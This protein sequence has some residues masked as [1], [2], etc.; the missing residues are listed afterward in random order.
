M[1][2]TL[3]IR[4]ELRESYNHTYAQ[5]HAFLGQTQILPQP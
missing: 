5:S 3:Y 4:W 2:V 1:K